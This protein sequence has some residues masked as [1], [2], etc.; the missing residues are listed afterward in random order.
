MEFSHL[1]PNL[2]L[3]SI[4]LSFVYV[5]IASLIFWIILTFS[6]WMTNGTV[7]KTEKKMKMNL[8][9]IKTI[10]SLYADFRISFLLLP[11]SK[12]KKITLPDVD[13]SDKVYI[14]TGGNSGCG[15]QT[16]F[17][18]GQRRA[19]VILACRSKEKAMKAV[20]TLK[21]E[22]KN[23]KIEF[24]RLDLSSLDSV[25]QFADEYKR[26]GLPCHALI[27]NAGL[28]YLSASFAEELTTKD[29]KFDMQFISNYLGHFLLTNLLIDVLIKSK[30]K[31]INISS[32]LHW[33]GTI[34][35]QILFYVDNE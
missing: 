14:I 8:N 3:L 31:I 7:R 13:L 17:Y 4:V 34:S 33:L 24:M 30:A 5:P 27:N 21:K 26:R 16:A 11:F 10:E 25:R 35:A 19:R 32:I 9:I 12:N 29:G 6:F 20:E 23:D 22:T 28:M 18:L 2:F 15:Y 1:L